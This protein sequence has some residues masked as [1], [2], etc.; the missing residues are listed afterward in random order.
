MRLYIS[1]AVGSWRIGAGIKLNAWNFIFVAFG[2][3]IYAAIYFTALLIDLIIICYYYLFKGFIFLCKKF[4]IFCRFAFRKA[5]DLVDWVI[6]KI[7]EKTKS[8]G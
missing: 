8:G 4:F 6:D 3:M 5:V 7:L 2:A 1:K